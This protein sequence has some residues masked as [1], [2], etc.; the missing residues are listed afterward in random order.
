M[1]SLSMK[2]FCSRK[3]ILMLLAMALIWVSIALLKSELRPV[4]SSSDD[5][6]NRPNG[7]VDP[8]GARQD[9]DTKKDERA[10]ATRRVDSKSQQEIFKSREETT[11]IVF[12]YGTYIAGKTVPVDDLLIELETIRSKLTKSGFQK[13]MEM[14]ATSEFYNPD[15][16]AAVFNQLL[17]VEAGSGVYPAYNGAA[18]EWGFQ[19]GNADEFFQFIDA[20]NSSPMR[21]SLTTSYYRRYCRTVEDLLEVVTD[22]GDLT[23][24]SHLGDNA[25]GRAHSVQEIVDSMIR[26]KLISQAEAIDAMADLEID[27]EFKDYLILSVQ[28]SGAYPYGETSGED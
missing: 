22:Q 8:A 25:L 10:L 24:P 19:P 12:D 1:S 28:R 11:N 6:E 20:L 27:P 14:F 2:I 5:A 18:R 3:L 17:P 13:V 26:N 21:R 23:K 4:R 15:E 16:K 9:M 7:I